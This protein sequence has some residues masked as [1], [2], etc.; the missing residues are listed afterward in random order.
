[1]ATTNKPVT[2]Y[3]TT[4]EEARTLIESALA[5]DPRLTHF[6]I[7]VFDEDMR[8]HEE[9]DEP[10]DADIAKEREHLRTAIAEVQRAADW[11][12][13][14]DSTARYNTRHNSYGYK[15]AVERWW[16]D[17]GAPDGNPYVANGAFIAAAIGL[18]WEAKVDGPNARF[19]FSERTYRLDR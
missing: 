16:R 2:P 18:G 15:H 13:R 3:E 5:K 1:M 6:G 14:Q 4:E 10:V 9:G 17:R 11:I 8:R 7:G 12:K 19:K